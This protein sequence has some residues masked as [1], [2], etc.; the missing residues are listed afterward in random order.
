[1]KKLLLIGLLLVIAGCGIKTHIDSNKSPDFSEKITKLYILVKQS[2]SSKPFLYPFVT[3][4]ETE[5]TAK[6]IAFE[7][8]YMDPLSLESEEDIQKKIQ[9]YGPNTVMIISQSES[10][11]T[12]SS[13]TNSGFGSGFNNG[14]GGFGG[15]SSGRTISGG[16]FDIK[17][18]K[19][20]GKNPVWRA[21]LSADTPSGIK[22]AVKKA[23]EIFIE[24]LISDKLI[25]GPA[26][27]QSK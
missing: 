22:K 12:H 14:Y 4:F 26:L 7:E 19:P 1:M 5:L 3:N 25:D 6:G 10:R 17:I 20:A 9:D 15:S 16:T 24:K 13:H 23:N 8:Y 27:N 11:I 2:D 21:N 18:F